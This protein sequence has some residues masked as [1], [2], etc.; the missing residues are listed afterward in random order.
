MHVTESRILFF[1]AE[2]VLG[3]QLLAGGIHARTERG[4]YHMVAID[5]VKPYPLFNAI[6]LS[7][8]PS[9]FFVTNGTN[10]TT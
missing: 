10:T 7:G 5:G 2:S 6:V 4:D 1:S 9:P 8:E 3:W